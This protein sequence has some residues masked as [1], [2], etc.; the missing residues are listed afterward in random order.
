MEEQELKTLAETFRASSPKLK[1]THNSRGYGWEIVILSNDVDEL[2][3][4]NEEMLKRFGGAHD[5]E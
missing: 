3:R 1:L 4:I 5:V 2:E